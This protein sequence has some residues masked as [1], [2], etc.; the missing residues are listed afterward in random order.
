[1]GKKEHLNLYLEALYSLA[2]RKRK[3]R[4]GFTKSRYLLSGVFSYQAPLAL[5]NL[6]RSKIRDHLTDEQS[7]I[8]R[9]RLEYFTTPA[10][11]LK[12]L[13]EIA[14]NGG[15]ES[16]EAAEAVV[17]ILKYEGRNDEALT[18][19]DQYLTAEKRKVLIKLQRTKAQ[20]YEMESKK[21][22]AAHAYEEAFKMGDDEI[23]EKVISLLQELGETERQK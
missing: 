16:I 21:Q 9:L 20:I 1:M 2:P 12:K 11:T 5:I 10:R 13:M 22:K 4:V 18:F 15:Y 6:F 7:G 8:H 17:E 14:E 19:Q 3:K 23:L